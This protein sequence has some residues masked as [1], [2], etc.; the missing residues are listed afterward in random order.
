MKMRE[1]QILIT[2]GY[3]IFRMPLACLSI[4]ECK[5]GGAWCT[6]STHSTMAGMKRAWAVLMADENNLEG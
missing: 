6:Y 5:A 3:R 2:A 1:Q 4:K